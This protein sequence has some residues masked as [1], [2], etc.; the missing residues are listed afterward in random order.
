MSRYEFQSQ[1]WV[2]LPAIDVYWGGTG[3]S[4]LEFTDTS[5]GSYFK[6]MGMGIEFG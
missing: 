6:G 5:A 2:R 1:G 4:S 3:F